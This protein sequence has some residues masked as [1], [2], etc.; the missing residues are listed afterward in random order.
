M[1]A[2]DILRDVAL[3]VI[4]LLLQVLVLNRIALFNIAI[5]LLYIFFIIKMPIGRNRFY[6]VLS[7]FIFGLAIDIFLNTPGVNAAALTTIATLRPL[8]LYLFYPKNES[9]AMVPGV[10]SGVKAFVKYVIVMVVV[11]QIILFTIDAMALF[12]VSR[13]FLR[14]VSSSA[15]TIILIIAADSLFYRRR[16]V[17]G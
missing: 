1:K 6:V 14:I 8:F 13:L 5:P 11:H 17:I 3:F 12:D 15:L 16:R 2:V 10:K 4:L 9:E 7:G